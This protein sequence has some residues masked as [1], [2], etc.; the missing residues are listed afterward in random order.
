MR[1]PIYVIEG[2]QLDKNYVYSKRIFY[3]DRETFMFYA[4][5]NYDQKDRLYRTFEAGIKFE[6][7]MGA[8]HNGGSSNLLKDHIDT[9]SCI[10]IS[11]AIPAFWKRKDVSLNQYLDAK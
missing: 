7:E 3:V 1:R 10:L 8:F 9:H 6:P 2:K 11:Y 5:M 4:V